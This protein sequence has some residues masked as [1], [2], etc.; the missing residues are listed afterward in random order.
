MSIGKACLALI[1]LALLL[2]VGLRI[3]GG[4]R[5]ARQISAAQNLVRE[6]MKEHKPISRAVSFFV[7]SLMRE[8]G[9]V[10]TRASADS[11]IG[12]IMVR[13]RLPQTKTMKTQQTSGRISTRSGQSFAL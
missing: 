7:G 1:G 8:T 9:S 5:E 6:H 10:G 3:E 12:S 11:F 13:L 2:A 4:F